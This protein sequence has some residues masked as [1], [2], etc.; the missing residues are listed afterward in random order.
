MPCSHASNPWPGGAKGFK[1]Y[2]RRHDQ[3]AGPL[4]AA[5]T[6][7][8]ARHPVRLSGTPAHAK[9]ARGNKN[10]RG[11]PQSRGSHR[12][13]RA[14][15]HAHVATDAGGRVNRRR[16][17]RLI[18]GWRSVAR[19]TA[20]IRGKL[21]AGECISRI[22][23]LVAFPGFSEH[24]TGGALD[25]GSPGVPQLD[26]RFARTAGFRWLRRH[27]SRF[28]FHLSYPRGNP[29]GIGHEPWHWCWRD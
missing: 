28:G 22:L 17:L 15:R 20:I 4:N 5:A 29:P 10:R 18:S 9:A 2:D 26:E 16:A 27:G 21:A 6:A 25:L 13:T 1:P 11:W 3:R 14:A 12:K 23:R 19:Q 24:H 8:C 7:G